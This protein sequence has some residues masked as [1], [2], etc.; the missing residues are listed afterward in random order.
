MS[1]LNSAILGLADSQNVTGLTFQLAA[2]ISQAQNE[3]FTHHN[4]DACQEWS[5]ISSARD[6]I[7]EHTLSLFYPINT[8]ILVV[9]VV[10]VTT[11]YPWQPSAGSSCTVDRSLDDLFR[12]LCCLDERFSLAC[13]RSVWLAWNR[14]LHNCQ[15]Q[16]NSASGLQLPN[17]HHRDD[18]KPASAASGR[19]C[20]SQ[21]RC[22][23]GDRQNFHRC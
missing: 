22:P 2:H 12:P 18:C 5:M 23:L 3:T 7:N 20:Q 13:H 14:R 9:V 6:K 1:L 15:L 11:H 8:F 19:Y 21:P 17:G 10:Q 4:G 16:L